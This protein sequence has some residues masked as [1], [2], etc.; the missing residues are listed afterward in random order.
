MFDLRHQL[1]TNASVALRETPH[2]EQA[3]RT[4]VSIAANN[5]ILMVEGYEVCALPIRKNSVAVAWPTVNA[6]TLTWLGSATERMRNGL[7]Q[8][9]LLLHERA[10]R[11]RNARARQTAPKTVLSQLTPNIQS[12][13]LLVDLAPH[14]VRNRCS[15]GRKAYELYLHDHGI[16]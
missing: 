6:P 12:N 11:V 4:I 5:P 15:V 13:A 1:D 2:R 14:V 7:R 3:L 10:N 16:C 8:R 9:I